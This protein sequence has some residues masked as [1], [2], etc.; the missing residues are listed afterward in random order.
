MDWLD[1]W[2]GVADCA[3]ALE[4]TLAREVAPGHPLH[5]VLV[6]AIGRHGGCDDVLYRLLEGS[7][8]VAVVH[9][10]YTHS[11]PEQLPWPITELFAS[12]E[13][14]ADQRM[15]LDHADPGRR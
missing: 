13:A 9:L 6:A 14:F 5:G 4:Q 2:R 3:T 10:T 8:R 12:P 11:P 1:P 7:G 15:A